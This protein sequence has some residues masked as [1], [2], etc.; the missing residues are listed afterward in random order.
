MK[1]GHNMADKPA[2]TAEVD[3]LENKGILFLTGPMTDESCGKVIT[4][5]I[6]ANMDP[7]TDFIQLMVSSPGGGVDAGFALIDMMRWSK[8]PIYT[9]GFGVVASMAVSV[10]IAGEPGRRIVTPN[11][12]LLT[13]QFM[14]GR[15]ENYSGLVAGRKMEDLTHQRLIQLYLECSQ[16]KTPEEVESKLMNGVD[17]WLTPEEALTVGLIDQIYKPARKALKA[18]S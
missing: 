17:T 8:L 1:E 10:L 5:I 4:G 16:F 9:T 14:W 7:K 2:V 12:T 3:V 13:H 15:K 18:V 6:K 11:T